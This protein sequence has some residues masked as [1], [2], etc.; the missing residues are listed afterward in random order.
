VG[1]W[2]RQGTPAVFPR[3]ALTGAR[4]AYFCRAAAEA[5]RAV[6]A[7]SDEEA[8]GEARPSAWA[9]VEEGEVGRGLGPRRDGG[10]ARGA[11]LHGDAALGPQRLD[12]QGM[13][14]DDPL[15]RT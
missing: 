3:R 8:G 6:F 9:G 11:G 12:Q 15:A 14:G 4:P 7:K 13:G 5:A 1:P 2:R 10:V